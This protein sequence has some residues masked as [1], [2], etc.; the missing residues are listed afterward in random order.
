[1]LDFRANNNINACLFIQDSDGNIIPLRGSA[2]GSF[3][4]ITLATDNVKMAVGTITS[5]PPSTSTLKDLSTNISGATIPNQITIMGLVCSLSTAS[6]IKVEIFD[7]STKLYSD[8]VYDDDP[9]VVGAPQSQFGGN[10]SQFPFINR[11]SANK[12]HFRI[13]NDA[14]MPTITM[15]L[16][17]F[18]K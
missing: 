3:G 10:Y 15:S 12:V 1:M 7:K 14:S 18:Y 11:D 9:I 16:K 8:K 5:L 13:T 17:L 4:V 2:D 6:R